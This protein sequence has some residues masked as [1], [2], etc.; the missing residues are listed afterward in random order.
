MH[1]GLEQKT[2]TENTHSRRDGKI[3][4]RWGYQKEVTF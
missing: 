4:D 2:E 3:T 1:T